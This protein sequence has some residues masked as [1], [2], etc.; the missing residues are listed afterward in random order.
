MKDKKYIC[1]NEEIKKSPL[2]VVFN[3]RTD[4]FV[5]TVLNECVIHN[6]E[7]CGKTHIRIF[8]KHMAYIL[9]SFE[10][11]LRTMGIPLHVEAEKV[12]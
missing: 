10:E 11:R 4:D 2:S 8:E 7:N 5:I 1:D 6:C 9:A 3:T 12:N